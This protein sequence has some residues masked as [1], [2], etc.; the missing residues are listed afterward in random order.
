M[1]LFGVTG[2]IFFKIIKKNPISELFPSNEQSGEERNFRMG[3]FMAGQ[4][5]RTTE[6][7]TSSAAKQP[8]IEFLQVKNR[9]KTVGR[10]GQPPPA[11]VTPRVSPS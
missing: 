11:L 7:P 10:R 4:E 2:L 6:S 3:F 8:K 9:I 1:G 5:V